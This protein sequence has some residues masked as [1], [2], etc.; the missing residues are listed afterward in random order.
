MQI[1]NLPLTQIEA[2][3]FL[4]DRSAPD[5]AAQEDLLLSILN[6]GLRQPIEVAELSE[7]L[8]GCT[9]ALVSGMRRL[10]AM[11]AIAEMQGT[12]DSATIP[13]ILRHPKSHSAIQLNA[14]FGTTT[15]S[16]LGRE[17]GE[18]DLAEMTEIQTLFC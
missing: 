11:R 5:E 17:F 10:T 9:H 6:D 12:S 1:H 14:P 18:E 15:R 7:P 16:G 8:N 2:E 4:R 3:A 13:V